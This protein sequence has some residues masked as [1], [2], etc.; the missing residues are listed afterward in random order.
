MRHY[1]LI[2]FILLGCASQMKP[3][4]GP[5]D[6][7]G[8]KVIQIYP[9]NKSI[10]L[11]YKTNIILEFDELIDPISAVNAVSIQNFSDFEYKVQGKKL[12]ITPINKWPNHN[13]LKVTINRNISDMR[14]NVI[15]SPIQLFYFNQ[16]SNNNKIIQ[17][18]IT[19][20]NSD[21]FELGLYKIINNEYILTEKLQSDLSGN[22]KF[23]YLE[24]G[25]YIVAAIQN[26][27]EDIERDIRIKKFGFI[28]QDAID[29][30]KS[31]TNY[32]L[33]KTGLP[34]ER[35]FIQSFQQINNKF[36]YFILN[37]G[38]E[39]PFII[40]EKDTGSYIK[41]DSL[42]VNLKLNNRIESYS[43][44]EFKIFLNDLVDTL[45]PTINNHYFEDD[46]YYIV[47]NEPIKNPIFYYEKDSIIN[48]IKYNFINSFSIELSPL[49]DLEL[50]IAKVEDLY[51]NQSNDTTSIF[52][53]SNIEEQIYNGGS[54]YGQINYQ[55]TNLVMVKAED[56]NSELI[57][58][59][60][61]DSNQDFSFIN[62]K[63]GFYK[64]SAYEI[65]ADYDSTVYFSGYWPFKR[66]AKFG[67][68]P[69]ILEV[70]NLWDF[71]N[72]KIV[73]E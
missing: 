14:S 19:N 52:I 13:T 73:V 17:G 11:D 56:L 44:P 47:F 37:N 22:F 57:Y 53:E 36:G 16:K 15:S 25:K 28:T 67:E 63:P 55:D 54:V 12:I 69:E 33:I 70:R 59:S 38:E 8:P 42:L 49:D 6:T 45:A 39:Y 35:L 27:I 5:I 26:N 9:E 65:L 61:V 7:E 1:I 64:F 34:I 58:Y 62:I 29:V 50:K 68:Y 21:I 48:E 20:I 66:A 24:Q 31:D 72:M 2:A 43:T 3:S 71:K 23:S 18:S 10:I 30:F 32:V 51:G 41:G 46:K 40:P 60:A 4:G